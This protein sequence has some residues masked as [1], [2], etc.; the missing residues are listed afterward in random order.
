M[1]CTD[2]KR[3]A[4][5]SSRPCR[6]PVG[7]LGRRGAIHTTARKDMH[8]S[9]QSRRF[10]SKK[11]KNLV[12][13][14]ETL[15]FIDATSFLS[16]LEPRGGGANRS[17]RWSD[18]PQGVGQIA[19]PPSGSIFCEDEPE[20]GSGWSAQSTAGR[21]FTEPG[22]YAS[23][24]ARTRFSS[25]P[26]TRSTWPTLNGSTNRSRPLTVFLS[27]AM[28]AISGDASRSEPAGSTGKP[29]DFRS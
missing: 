4:G 11:T 12:S 2:F 15:F 21:G 27:R 22:G 23:S 17:R 26:S 24:T 7:S 29:M 25:M 20:R 28:T 16:T 13:R 9:C 5:T 8:V 19:P 1:E 14:P 10:F 6:M 3:S 18:S